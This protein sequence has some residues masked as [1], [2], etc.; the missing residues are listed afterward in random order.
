MF[1]LSSGSWM[2]VGLI[3]MAKCLM[4]RVVDVVAG[5]VTVLVQ[6]RTVVSTISVVSVSVVIF[7]RQVPFRLLIKPSL[8]SQHPFLR[9]SLIDWHSSFS[10]QLSTPTSQLF[11]SSEHCLECGKEIISLKYYIKKMAA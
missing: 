3:W 7:T 6:G 9:R 1:D 5:V 11:E 8:H 4:Y 10:K 2:D